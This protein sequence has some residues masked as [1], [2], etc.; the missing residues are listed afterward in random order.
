M[1]AE[2]PP[3]DRQSANKDEQEPTRCNFEQLIHFGEAVQQVKTLV[4]AGE[5]YIDIEAKVGTFNFTERQRELFLEGVSRLL[6][7]RQIV[8]EATD[9]YKDEHQA[10][11]GKRLFMD[12]VKSERVFGN[13]EIHQEENALVFVCEDVIDIAQA[14]HPNEDFSGI[15]DNIDPAELDG[16]RQSLTGLPMGAFLLRD[17]DIP[18]V[19]QIDSCIFIDGSKADDRG[20]DL[21]KVVDHEMQ[22]SESSL[23][24][25]PAFANLEKTKKYILAIAES[26]TAWEG[27][28]KAQL[29]VESSDAKEKPEQLENSEASKKLIEQ[30]ILDVE[31]SAESVLRLTEKSV[32]ETLVKEEL[33]AFFFSG[34]KSE[35]I[36][37]IFF[38]YIMATKGTFLKVTSLLDEAVYK[39][40]SPALLEGMGIDQHRLRMSV[41]FKD[42]REMAGTISEK[43]S[44]DNPI[45]KLRNNLG[46]RI[47]RVVENCERELERGLRVLDTIRERHGADE[48]LMGKI[49]PILISQPISRWEEIVA[50]L[51]AK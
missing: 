40:S 42:L 28:V 21:A 32:I 41:M 46:K 26:V 19:G 9:K 45:V 7:R 10:E 24:Y 49:K 47:E 27:Q 44:E 20:E 33:L 16:F 14:L 17:F 15:P 31:D 48:D 30:I 38:D 3:I 35:D 39:Y 1:G 8:K 13:I 37:D 50:E 25:R 11:A 22:H 34:Q 18:E 2:D 29:A 43:G 12:V 36:K 4:E 6:N 23:Y 5:T 51:S